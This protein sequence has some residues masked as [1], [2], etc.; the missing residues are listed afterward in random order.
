MSPGWET[1][2]AGL[3]RGARAAGPPVRRVPL[4]RWASPARRD[5]V[6]SGDR[7]PAGPLARPDRLPGGDPLSRWSPCPVGPPARRN[8][9]GGAAWAASSCRTSRRA[10]WAVSGAVGSGSRGGAGAC[11]GITFSVSPTV[12]ASDR[13]AY[14]SECGVCFALAQKCS[15]ILFPRAGYL[16]RVSTWDAAVSPGRRGPLPEPPAHPRPRRLSR[17]CFQG[18]KHRRARRGAAGAGSQQPTRGPPSHTPPG[19]HNLDL[20]PRPRHDKPADGQGAILMR[21]AENA[22]CEHRENRWKKENMRIRKGAAHVVCVTEL[23]V[24]AVFNS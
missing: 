17:P 10:G 14:S 22:D 21:S 11:V 7:C 24:P 18:W 9:L 13:R 20:T 1:G 23:K 6:S 12:C 2:A 15:L 3:P 5:P 8:G 16:K 4:A 19:T